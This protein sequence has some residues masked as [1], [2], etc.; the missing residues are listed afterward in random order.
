VINLFKPE[1][2]LV[3]FEVSSSALTM[4]R[5]SREKNRLQLEDFT[6][7][8]LEE[9]EVTISMVEE[10]V[11][12]ESYLTEVIRRAA[13][14]IGDKKSDRVSVVLSDSTAKVTVLEMVSAPRNRKEMDRL[15][16]WQLKKVTPFPIEEGRVG[17]HRFGRPVGNA[18]DDHV[19]RVLV[20][21]MRTTVLRQYERCFANAGLHAGLVDISTNNLYNL[22]RDK[23][24][25]GVGGGGDC[26]LVNC[27]PDGLSLVML[28]GGVPLLY[29]AKAVV[30]IR[31]ANDYEYDRVVREI[32]TSVLYYQEKLG[33]SELGRVLIRGTGFHIRGLRD[34]LAAEMEAPVEV[35]DPAGEI[36][37]RPGLALEPGALQRLA[38][39]IGAACGR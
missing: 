38:P 31:G 27:E 3:S 1:Y 35:L 8:P 13:A 20:T 5:L 9:G 21:I 22:F 4:V 36:S 15:I 11:T 30:A 24:A 37:V 12:R 14:R 33:R 19:I 32:R 26:L 29:R 16:A 2:P 28:H 18:E 25:N 23:I 7:T 10:N 39:A 34:Q 6:V 17:Y